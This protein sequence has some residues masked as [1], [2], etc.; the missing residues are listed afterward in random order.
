MRPGVVWFDEELPPLEVTRIESFL[1]Q[2]E[3]DLV[4]VVGT[5]ANFDYVFDWALRARGKG[6]LLVEINPNET[7]LSSIADVCIR[8]SASRALRRLVP[9]G[10]AAAIPSPVPLDTG[11][12]PAT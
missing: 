10:A 11:P 2:G 9:D 7:P 4:L 12:P 1:E 6:G 3:C 8:S 5:S